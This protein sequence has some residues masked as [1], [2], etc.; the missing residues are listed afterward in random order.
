M[1]VGILGCGFIGT[2]IGGSLDQNPEV[3]EIYLLDSNY[4]ATVHLAGVLKKGR[5]KREFDIDEFIDVSDLV[6]E[7]ASQAAV[8]EVGP[9]VLEAGKDLMI[10]S[11]GALVEDDLWKRLKE[12]AKGKECRIHIP[13]GAIAG[14]DGIIS[15]SIADIDCITLTVRKPPKGLS[16]PSSLHEK[17]T[18]LSELREPLV[19]FEGSAREAVKVFP[20]NVNVAATIALAGIGFDRTR[21]RMIAD[22]SVSSNMHTIEVRGR[23][24]EM[25]VEMFNHPSTTNPRT[26]YLAPL[27]AIAS[28]DRIITGINI[29]N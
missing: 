14:I 17:S 27:S 7:A 3:D 13:S 1:N 9:R 12:T 22:P 20:K 25:K 24:G 26:S 29:G 6:V 18:L 23:F 19:L 16:L 28:L 15:A 4:E 8:K 10:M 5:I 21:V 11:V 2:T